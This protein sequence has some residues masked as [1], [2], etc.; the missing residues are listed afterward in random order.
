MAPPALLTAVVA[1]TLLASAP[2]VAGRSFSIDHASDSFLKDGEPFRMVSGSVH[3]FRMTPDAWPDRLAKLRYAGLNTVATYVEWA[4][5]E[6]EPGRYAFSG[7]LDL[8]AF[9]E[10]AARQGLLVNL[11]VGPYICAERD[12]GGFPYW[13][14]REH[15]NITMRT[16]D[17]DFMTRV[18]SWLL[19]GLFPRVRHLLYEN[20]GPIIM[21]Q[22]ENEYGLYHT[23]LDAPYHS[24]NTAYLEHLRDTFVIGLGPRALLYSTDVPQTVVCGKTQGVYATIDFGPG[25]RPG[26]QFPFQRLFEPTGPLVNSEYYTGWIDHWGEPKHSKDTDAVVAGLDAMLAMNASVNFYMFFG[27][28]NFGFGAGAN[29]PDDY[30]SVPTSYDYS[31]PLSEAGD[32]TEKYWAIRDTVSKYLPLPDMPVPSNSTKEAY[33]EVILTYQGHFLGTVYGEIS[34]V[35][36]S[37]SPLTFEELSTFNG[38]VAYTTTVPAQMAGEHSLE[39]GAAHDRTLVYLN[40]EAL[41]AVE[42][43]AGNPSLNMALRGGD[44]L[45]LAVESL[46]HVTS[47]S[48]MNDYK[49]LTSDVLLGTHVLSNWSMSP[50]PLQ[51]SSELNVAVTK[52]VEQNE[53]LNECCGENQEQCQ[54]AL[55]IT[56]DADV[57]CKLAGRTNVGYF[58]GNLVIDGI[59]KD[60]FLKLDGWTKGVAYV[61]G[62]NLGRYWPAKGPQQT[63]YVP[64]GALL[65]GPNRLLLLELEDSGCAEGRCG[66]AFQD[67]PELN[68][69]PGGEA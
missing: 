65:E 14:L 11:R 51:N 55:G 25:R 50:L 66:V 7:G 3:Y 34:P 38:I 18:D 27:G 22:P 58:A 15:P 6:P 42:R 62:F 31:A 8:A 29:D 13:L 10:E 52:L 46:G 54:D 32:M 49:G 35:V 24:C 61:N 64:A 20:G 48:Q 60:T 53:I 69:L 47:G 59:P 43:A 36:I 56:G 21:V 37:E 63:L 4:S 67:T 16:D 2:R 1:G 68:T 9:I 57:L 40:G 44:V 30:K 23:P 19:D 33:G 5:H 17:P 12:L 28:T 45:T 26:V 41:G 39:L